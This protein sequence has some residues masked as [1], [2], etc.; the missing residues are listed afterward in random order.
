MQVLCLAGGRGEGRGSRKNKKNKMEKSQTAPPPKKSGNFSKIVSVRLS[1]SVKRFRVSRMQNLKSQ[2]LKSE[3]K[4]F[5]IF[6]LLF[7]VGRYNRH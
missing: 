2:S 1:A 5:I 7:S 6:F 3:K 4:I